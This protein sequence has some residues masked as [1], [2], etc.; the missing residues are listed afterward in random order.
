MA[1][2]LSD[3]DFAVVHR[4]IVKHQAGDTL[5]RIQTAVG[6]TTQVEDDLPIWNLDIVQIKRDRKPFVHVARNA[7]V[8]STCQQV[9]TTKLPSKPERR[10]LVCYSRRTA[11]RQKIRYQQWKSSLW[12]RQRT[13]IVKNLRHKSE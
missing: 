8:R 10:D 13:R 7:S 9:G 11:K 4:A 2:K 6:E 12:K 5:S 3:F 1:T